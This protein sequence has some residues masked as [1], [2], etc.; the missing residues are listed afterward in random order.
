MALREN[1]SEQHQQHWLSRLEDERRNLSASVED[2]LNDPQN[3]VEE[4][5]AANE[6]S[7]QSVIP[8][9]LSLQ[10]KQ[11]PAV[12]SGS[13]VQSAIAAQTGEIA[14]PEGKQDRA[15]SS[16]QRGNVFTRFAQKL[17][18][19]LPIFGST[20][21]TDAFPVLP[22]PS[23]QE[24]Q[25][26]SRQREVSLLPST[27]QQEELLQSPDL[28][29]PT[30]T[31]VYSENANIDM[32]EVK[33]E[34]QPTGPI[35]IS[36]KQRLAGHTG[37]IHLETT[38]MPVV[39]LEVKAPKTSTYLDELLASTATRSEYP[40]SS[41]VAEKPVTWQETFSVISPEQGVLQQA[42]NVAVDRSAKRESTAEKTFGSG[43][44]E[45]GQGDITVTNEMVCEHSVVL[46]TLTSN[47]GP[48]VVQYISLQPQHGFTL[49]LTA[50]ATQ[51]ATFNYVVTGGEL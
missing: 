13:F 32:P 41:E 47:P 25:L 50:P 45:A 24:K 23:P 34:D 48:V 42:A 18:A 2:A 5:D 20:L 29:V 9:R 12:Q 8:P 14:T 4:E 49:H 39:E 7:S 16:P 31:S 44:I 11:L 38:P 36:N 26:L 35:P 6:Q 3:P 1:V 15:A 46:V 17:T 37:R 22:P 30:S 28:S 43:A 40:A 51:K 19:S 27:P 33:S 21:H 10:S